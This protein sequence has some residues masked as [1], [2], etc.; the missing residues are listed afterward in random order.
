M[1]NF[2][3]Y[4][5]CDNCGT[6]TSSAHQAAPLGCFTVQAGPCEALP[7]LRA[8]VASVR[9]CELLLPHL[10]AGARVVASRA[11]SSASQ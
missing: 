6:Y 3:N 5:D 9:M 10:T 11:S 8:E 4:R 2:G 7:A 1:R